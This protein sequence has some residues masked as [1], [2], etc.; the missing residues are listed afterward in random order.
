MIIKSTSRVRRLLVLL[1]VSTP[2]V[3]IGSTAV[4]GATASAQIVNAQQS[5]NWA[6][7]VAQSKDGQHFSSVSGRW[8]QP[9]VSPGSGTGYSAYWVGLGGASKS[10]KALEQ[11]G[12]S[13]NVVNGKAH[14]SAWY[15]LVPA[16]ETKLSLAVHP[17]DHMA[18]T[19]RVAGDEVTL[20]LDDQTTGQSVTKSLHMSGPD[21][22]SAEWIAEA[23]SQVTPGGGTQI[24]PLANFGK[25]TFTNAT[26]TAAGHTGPISDPDWT[27]QRTQLSSSGGLGF[28]GA[29]SVAGGLGALPGQAAAGAV[30]SSLSDSGTSFSVSY[31]GGVGSQWPTGGLPGSPTGGYGYGFGNPYVLVLPGG[32]VV[33][34]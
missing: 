8:V 19:V 27:V 20:S 34:V 26:A 7:Y 21:T 30:P 17:G 29:G 14:Y 5:Q 9:A 6:G 13:A 28:P 3:L 11:I 12:T 2:V 33:V 23:P 10:S 18:A 32:Y 1:A 22:S 25:V 31:S 15:E 24:L 4:T 16:P